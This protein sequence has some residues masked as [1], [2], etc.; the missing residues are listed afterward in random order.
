MDSPDEVNEGFLM[1][2]LHPKTQAFRPKFDKP[3]PP[4]RRGNNRKK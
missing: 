1:N 3:K 4:V 2:E